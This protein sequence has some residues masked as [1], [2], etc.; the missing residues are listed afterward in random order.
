MGAICGG[1]SEKPGGFVND[2]L[3]KPKIM[4]VYGDWFDADTRTVMVLIK[5]G[6]V[7]H[8]F[9]NIDQF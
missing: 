7:S 3:I 8:S 9:K 4:T 2:R 6:N 5:L 1:D